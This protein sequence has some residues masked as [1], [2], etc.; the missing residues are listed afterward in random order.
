MG[1]IDTLTVAPR[2]ETVV[3][4]GE[5]DGT[6]VQIADK[7][8]RAEQ[9]P[10]PADGKDGDDDAPDGNR[11]LLDDVGVKKKG[12]PFNKTR[13]GRI[14]ELT[15]KNS[16]SESEKAA[17]L[18]ELEE[19]RGGKESLEREKAKSD[20]A[21]VLHYADN[22]ALK[23]KEVQ[24]EHKDALDAGD[25]EK[26]SKAAAE[27]AEIAAKQAQVD[28]W[29]ANNPEPKEGEPEPKAA[30][31]EAEKP[32]QQQA[33]AHPETAAW[34]AA[35]PWFDQAKPEFDQARREEAQAFAQLLEARLRRAGNA[36]AI[37]SRDYF[38]L[39]DRHMQEAFGGEADDDEEEVT[40]QRPAP[41]RMTPGSG[42]A[43]ARSNA[44]GRAAE[45]APANPN[46]VRLTAEQ[47]EVAHALI[48]KHPNGQSYSTREKEVAYAKGLRLNNRKGA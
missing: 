20:R 38:D 31:R 37:G 48:L 17:L 26:A 7:V 47:R 14:A 3:D 21:A 34:I 32:K 18:A 1:E 10:P 4:I 6:G 9:E 43:P 45:E 16:Q 29:K 5:D 25:T 36:Q 11:N 13:D 24:R 42:V 22:L 27:M 19:L 8:A 44:T 35:N 46:S 2:G 33:P 15:R 23:R 28:A 30:P 40:T 41:P 39:I 12:K